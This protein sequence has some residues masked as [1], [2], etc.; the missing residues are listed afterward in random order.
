M[1]SLSN[2][3]QHADFDIRRMARK[4]TPVKGETQTEF[5]ID[6]P[7]PPMAAAANMDL[8]IRKAASQ[9]LTP[10]QEEFNKRMKALE[11]ARAAHDRKRKRL[12]KDLAV[13]RNE[14]MPLV[15]MRN[16][17]E[18]QLIFLVSEAHGTLKLTARRRIALE[19]LLLGKIV[20][21]RDDPTG[22]DDE[23]MAKLATLHDELD[24]PCDPDDAEEEEEDLDE[25]AREEFEAM[26]AMLE[27]AA[28]G[29]GV[30]LD[31]SGLDP[32]MDPEEFEQRVMERL[33]A[34][35]RDADSNKK[36]RRKRK[37]SKAALERERLRQEAEEAKKRDF[38]SLYKQLAKVL[39][40]DL[41]GDAAM[42]AQKESWMKRLTT[43]R[44]N[45]DLRE[46]LAIEV[47]WLGKE[48]GNL[49]KA[50]DEK[51]RVYSMVLKEQLAELKE[52]TK[53]LAHGS[54]YIPLR[55]FMTPYDDRINSNR[56]KV[57]MYGE[58]DG[59]KEI[60]SILQA[61]GPAA[62]KLIH[63]SADQ[64]ARAFGF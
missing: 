52:Q 56:I 58:I 36:T 26:R 27:G 11:R 40:P 12:D 63:E 46:M 18:Y 10:A 41:E 51:L 8:T 47:E 49:A 16:R 38:K 61:G 59:L 6:I 30:D 32:S 29:A 21:L 43:A 15:E 14:L 13:C 22:L 1:A 9:P 31:L 17:S 3:K 23:Q 57:R 50:T 25:Q 42:K 54:E 5:E 44:A 7:S 20:D 60:T 4:L 2:W 28:R 45:G 34:A 53:L 37:P 55:R 33:E 64:H 62:R 24:P 19:D 35:A 48:A 39:H